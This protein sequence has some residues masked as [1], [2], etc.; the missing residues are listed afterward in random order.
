[1]KLLKRFGTG[2]KLYTFDGKQTSYNDNFADLVTATSRMPGMD[3]G[4]DEYGSQRSPAEVGLVQAYIILDFNS[5][6]EA[7]TKVDDL[8][9][10]ADWGV[11]PLWMLP[12]QGGTERWCWAR[13]NSVVTSQNVKN[14]P[15]KRQAAKLTFQVAD[16]FWYGYGNSSGSIIGVDFLLGTSVFGGGSPSALSGL[17]NTVSITNAGN[18]FT[19]LQIVIQPADGQSCANPIVQRIENGDVVDQVRWYGTL[20][21]LDQLYIDARRQKVTLNGIG[22]YDAR[23]AATTGE[24]MR[25]NPGSNTIKILFGNTSDAANVSL[26]Y[27]E[28]YR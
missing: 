11:Q 16:P 6:V 9:K 26:R 1:M 28:R 3:G 20:A 5:I 25:L 8:R 10:I 14:T 24:W 12:T 17:S 18:A 2:S 7:T 23:F 22:A 15:H 21:A 4:F 13:V 19:Y 27:L